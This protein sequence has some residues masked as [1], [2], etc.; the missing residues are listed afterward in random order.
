LVGGLAARP[1][2]FHRLPGGES[3]RAHA[4]RLNNCCDR[5]DDKH[6]APH[7]HAPNRRTNIVSIKPAMVNSVSGQSQQEAGCFMDAAIS[8]SQRVAVADGV[9][10]RVGVAVRVGRGVSV[11]VEVM[12]GR[13]VRVREGVGVGRVGVGVLV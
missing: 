3:E 10:V 2:G 8:S 11:G 6:A 1:L 12:V 13:R 9:R 4:Q 7:H 5:K